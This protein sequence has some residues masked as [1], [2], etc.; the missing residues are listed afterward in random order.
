MYLEV[1]ERGSGKTTRLVNEIVDFLLENADK[2][3]LIV[4][5]LNSERK[6]IQ[7]KVHER[8][9]DLCSKRTITS[10]KMLE[11]CETIKQFVDEFDCML[12]ERLFLDK[13]AY[14]STTNCES[15]KCREIYDVYKQI[16]TGSVK[17]N[18]FIKKHEL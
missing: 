10:H 5:P 1:K 11:P 4:T 14:Y 18:K 3:A 13:E 2:A 7:K 17:P 16:K 8:C 6:F 12:P 9:G 15:Q